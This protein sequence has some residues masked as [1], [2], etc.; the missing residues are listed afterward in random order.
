MHDAALTT[1]VS[2]PRIHV[3]RIYPPWLGYLSER[4][5]C[6]LAVDSAPYALTYPYCTCTC[7]SH[8]HIYT[9]ARARTHTHTHTHSMQRVQRFCRLSASCWRF[10]EEAPAAC[11]SA[12]HASQVL[13]DLF[14]CLCVCVCVCVCARVC[15]CACVYVCVP[16]LRCPV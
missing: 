3:V 10:F 6:H 1:P 13:H 9:R 5:V 16:Y 7:I 2:L 12:S 14:V 11:A 15:V 4:I 8:T